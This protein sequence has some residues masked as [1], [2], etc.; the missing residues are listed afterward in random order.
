M[1]EKY[2]LMIRFEDQQWYKDMMRRVKL[3]V[4]IVQIQGICK[5]MV[6][7][8]SPVFE[9]LA[10][11]I[12]DIWQNEVKPKF[13][14]LVDCLEELADLAVEMEEKEKERKVWVSYNPP[15]SGGK[16]WY[17]NHMMRDQRSDIRHFTVNRRE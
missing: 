8:I 4:A 10:Q 16:T 13:D 2:E 5:Q 17:Y 12:V 3:R 11:Q 15:R 1:S 6:A 7:T 14:S 9:E